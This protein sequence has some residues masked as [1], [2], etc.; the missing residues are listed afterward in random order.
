MTSKIKVPSYLSLIE[1]PKWWKE[2]NN[3]C[4]LSSVLHINMVSYACLVP[5]K[6]SNIPTKVNKNT[7]LKINTLSPLCVSCC[8][9]IF[10]KVQETCGCDL[11]YGDLIFS[12]EFLSNDD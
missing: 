4:Q 11:K 9:G 7:I 12:S 3:F 8:I 6:C 10:S 5:H 2:R 1:G